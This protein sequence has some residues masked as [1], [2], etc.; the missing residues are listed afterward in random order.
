MYCDLVLKGCQSVLRTL[1]LVPLVL[2]FL[3][4]S[5]KIGRSAIQ[6][7]SYDASSS[8]CDTM[9]TISAVAVDL[10]FATA[11]PIACRMRGKM[12]LRP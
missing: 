3:F 10:G 1:V 5:A 11:N 8:C 7:S 2:V 9:T 6:A 12:A 4:G